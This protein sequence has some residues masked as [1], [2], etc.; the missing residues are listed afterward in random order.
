MTERLEKRTEKTIIKKIENKLFDV[1]GYLIDRKPK[2]RHK[3]DDTS[4]NNKL[5]HSYFYHSSKRDLIY[6]IFPY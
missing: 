3:T 1:V 5:I 4:Q 6:P 2:H